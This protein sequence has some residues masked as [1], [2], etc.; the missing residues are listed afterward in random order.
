MCGIV[1]YCNIEHAKEKVLNSL[2]IIQNRGTDAVGLGFKNAMYHANSLQALIQKT[3]HHTTHESIVFGHCLHAMVDFLPEP[4][5]TPK[6]MIIANCEIYNW[7]ELCNE[8][9]LF[10]KNDAELIGLLIEKYGQKNIA[11]T[12]A[13]LDGV[14]AF[15][16][17]AENQIIL[18]RDLFGVKPL[19]YSAADG[20]AFCSEKKVLLANGISEIQELNPRTIVMYHTTTKKVVAKKR[21]FLK[22]GIPLKI[23]QE[24]IIKELK[25][26]LVNAVSK[27]IPDQE[28][29]ILF[30]GGVDSTSIALICKSLGLNPTCYTAAI[31]DKNIPPAEDLIYAKKAAEQLGLRLHVQEISLKEVSAYLKKVVPLI[32]DNNVVKVGVA[33]PFYCACERARKDGVRVLFSGLGSE[34]LFAGYQRHK[35]AKDVNKE[36]YSGLLKMY[37]RDLYRDDVVTMNNTIELRLPFLDKTLAEYALRIPAGYKIKD[38]Q[39]KWI[40][41]KSVEQLGVSGEIAWR[42]KRAAQYG[43]RF[44]KALEKLAKQNGF[45]SKSAYL[46][47]FYQPLNLKLAVLFSSGKDSMYAL[48][49][50][51][52]QN[53][54]I[55]CLVTLRSKNSASYMFHT[56]N[57]HLASLQAKALGIPLIEQNTTGDK[58]AELKDLKTALQVAKKKYHIDG[59]VTGALFSQY[60]RERIEQVCD[61]LGLKIFSPLWHMD[62]E[63]LVKELIQQKFEII[64]GSIAADG[65]TKADLGKKFDAAL[66]AKLKN[67]HTKYGINVAGE[68]GE[69][70]SL[71]LDAPLFTKRI[72]IEDAEARME[73]PCTGTYHVKKAKLVDKKE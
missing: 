70:E 12:L 68:G 66:L 4:I 30:S 71:V 69:Y 18:A 40:L 29:G 55:T 24:Q 45:E 15:A 2:Q 72:V 13:L 41:R 37:E 38:N 50:M 34:E 16:Y 7:K 49:V 48:H 21:T 36:C 31:V 73:N 52:K 8:H 39:D 58:E 63:Q 64:L 19:W 65:F 6:G 59:V 25:G 57:L 23:S 20:L 46:A 54:D 27:R 56:P 22:E 28:M 26:L 5:K 32:E 62:Q 67:L 51:K 14:Y 60:Q 42:P 44:D 47:T 53:Y 3:K 35:Q 43:S 9:N 33:L 11:K 10:A 17:W 1:G 61:K